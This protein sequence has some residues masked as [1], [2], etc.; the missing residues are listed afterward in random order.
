MRNY[1]IPLPLLVSS[2][3]F[4]CNHFQSFVSTLLRL[5]LHSS[6]TLL[7]KLGDVG[8]RFYIARDESSDSLVTAA[9]HWSEKAGMVS[10]IK[11]L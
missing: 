4:Q 1:T 11:L 3:D 5:I 7:L 10:L 2:F 6:G 9:E 8:K